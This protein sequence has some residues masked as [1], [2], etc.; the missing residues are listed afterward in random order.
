MRA[1]LILVAALAGLSSAPAV[2]MKVGDI[3]PD[4]TRA[5]LAGKEVR[6]SGYRGKLVLLNFWATW[7]P[8]CREELPVFSRWQKDLQARGLQ[9]IG[10]SMDDDVAEVKK[11][12]AEYPVTF[13]IAMGGAKFAEQFGG[14]LGVPLTYLIDAQGRVVARYQGEADLKKM[15]AKVKELLDAK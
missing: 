8:P 7:C 12:L 5:D 9:V 1:W 11:F 14:V 6:L 3:A 2:A 13:P 15:E 4:F 10:L